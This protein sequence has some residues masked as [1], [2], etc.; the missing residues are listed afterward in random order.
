[1]LYLV[2]WYLSLQA[3]CGDVPYI[4]LL[5]IRYIHSIHIHYTVGRSDFSFLWNFEKKQVG[6]L[7]FGK[8][9]HVFINKCF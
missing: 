1:M 2:V 6:V 4:F 7:T 3:Q 9:T 5:D 8:K